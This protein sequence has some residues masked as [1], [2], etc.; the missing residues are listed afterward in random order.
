MNVGGVVRPVGV[1][2]DEHLEPALDSPKGSRPCTRCRAPC[3]DARSSTST[4]PSSAPTVFASRAARPGSNRR[5]RG[6][7]PQGAQLTPRTQWATSSSRSLCL[8]SGARNRS[9]DP[10][11]IVTLTV[12]FEC[13]DGWSPGSGGSGCRT[14]E[15]RGRVAV[16][17]NVD[18][19]GDGGVGE[20]AGC[21]G[22]SGPTLRRACPRRGRDG[23]GR[24][25]GRLHREA[26]PQCWWSGSVGRRGRR[27]RASRRWSARRWPS[28]WTVG[29]VAERDVIVEFVFDRAAPQGLAH[30]K[31]SVHPDGD[32]GRLPLCHGGR[33][34][35]VP[36]FDGGLRWPAAGRADSTARGL[37]ASLLSGH[38]SPG[39]SRC[40]TYRT[41]VDRSNGG[42]E[43]GSR[44]GQTR[45]DG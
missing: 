37:F 4:C 16:R 18:L 41:K 36:S 29:I 25:Q 32:A 20:A 6:R 12:V 45:P 27:A 11:V 43:A 2:L 26:A 17:G 19:R 34:H 5:P 28:S 15:P 44:Q 14:G 24:T 10:R 9:G 35:R 33:C 31:V 38:F 3:F 23:G 21:V 13:H 39:Q 8:T 1:H 22:S 40:A 42:H 7:A 30:A